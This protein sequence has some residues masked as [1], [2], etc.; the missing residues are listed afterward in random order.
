MRYNS[1]IEYVKLAAPEDHPLG[2]IH[3][4]LHMLINNCCVDGGIYICSRLLMVDRLL[5]DL[6]GLN[7][8]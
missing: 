6:T 5:H 1:I 2:S 7:K 4:V 3:V 8:S